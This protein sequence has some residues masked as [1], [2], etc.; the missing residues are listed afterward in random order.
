M[1]ADL[2]PAEIEWTRIEPAI[3]GEDV[4]SAF[5]PIVSDRP[6]FRAQ[7]IIWPADLRF[8][9]FYSQYDR[10]SAVYFKRFTEAGWKEQPRRVQ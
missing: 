2:G 6:R 1:A 5:A 3:V 4:L 9:P 8:V 10:R 7:G